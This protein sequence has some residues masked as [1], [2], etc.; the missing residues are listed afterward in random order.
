L[1]DGIRK[2]LR[3]SLVTFAVLDLLAALSAVPYGATAFLITW[4][5]SV[6][7]YD[8][9]STGLKAA[10][11]VILSSGVLLLV[12][13]GRLGYI[14]SF[15]AAASVAAYIGLWPYVSWLTANTADARAAS[16][17]VLFLGAAA[18]TV[19]ALAF[20]VVARSAGVEAARP[21]ETDPL[22]EPV[23]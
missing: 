12:S 21:R 16:A 6:V 19:A 22:I 10:P 8:I 17:V 13:G 15:I 5:S 23:A 1:Q 18:L 11:A 20:L 14:G 3:W 9:W 7:P 4:P 2:R